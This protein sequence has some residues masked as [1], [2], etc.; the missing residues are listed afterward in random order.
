MIGQ[1][2][3]HYKDHGLLRRRP[4]PLSR[5]A[6]GGNWRDTGT[7]GYRFSYPFVVVAATLLVSVPSF[8]QE[9]RRPNFVFILVDDL[10]WADIGAFNPRTFYDTPNIDRLAAEGMMFTNGYAANPVCSPTRYSIMTGKYPTRVGATNY[11]SGTREGRFAPAPL[12]DRMPRDEITLAEALR[13][14]GY[15][16]AFIGKWHLG[17]TQEFW[18]VAQGFEVNIGGN[19]RGAPRTFFAPYGNPNLVDGPDGEHLTARLTDETLRLMEEFRDGPFL[20][21]LAYY[22]VHVYIRRVDGNVELG[23][24]APDDLVAKYIAKARRLDPT[25]D[26]APEF[27]EEEQVW[28]TDERRR[29]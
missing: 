15:K 27:S 28:P 3:A 26:D 25:S 20:L 22:T 9:T 21:Y 11:F 18:P 16:S 5:H 7:M 14:A 24:E 13:P 23:L 29:I 12:N 19:E 4:D 1:T 17:P 10:G 8:A 6:R 2:L